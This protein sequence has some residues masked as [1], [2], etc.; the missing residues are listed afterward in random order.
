MATKLKDLRGQIRAKREEM[1]GFFKK[2]GDGGRPVMTAEDRDK[3]RA[4][5]AELSTLGT[6][7]DSERELA[8]IEKKNR[9][10]IDAM[11]KVRVPGS[12][13]G[14]GGRYKGRIGGDGASL[15]DT[16]GFR[17][18]ESK[19][20]KGTSNKGGGREWGVKFPDYETKTLFQ[21]TA[22]FD[23]FVPRQ[24]FISLSP[25]QQPKV[26]DLLPTSETTFH[27]IKWM[28]ETLFTNNAAATAEGALY[29]EAALSFTEQLSPVNKISVFL[30]ATDE[31]LEDAPRTRDL[32]NNR[33]TLM[34]RQVLDQYLINGNGTAPQLTGL[35]TLANR[36][37]QALGTDP[38]P[39]ALYK[40]MTKIRFTG[41]SE[42]TG[43]IMN[44][45]DWQGIK[46]LQTADGLYIWGHP[47]EETVNRIWGLPVVVTTYCPQSHAIV[48]D[49]MGQTE[50]IWRK[51][52]EFLVSNSHA[53]FFQRGQLA[54]RADM[55][56]AFICTRQTA[57]C[58]VTGLVAG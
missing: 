16:V 9:Q 2:T 17:F 41:F 26:V 49:F 42:P 28:L 50:L 8:T 32:L 37:T 20:Y 36:L 11:N 12:F 23:P 48:A 1:D 47:S 55:R 15:N 43:V 18:I 21:T 10:A 27:S 31:Q 58:E 30:P 25:Q 52:M 19:S 29:P 34:L 57:V 4:L 24:P 39:S 45:L 22:G 46:L 33:L 56:A 6:E 14:R 3:V 53:D 40:A 13:E 38:A 35:L 44:P 51:G 54:I 7:Y 5:H